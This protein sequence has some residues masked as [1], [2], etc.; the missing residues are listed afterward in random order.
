MCRGLS[1]TTFIKMNSKEYKKLHKDI[2]ETLEKTFKLADEMKNQARLDFTKTMEDLSEIYCND[3]H[4]FNVGDRV[5]LKDK[6]W[7]HIIVSSYRHDFNYQDCGYI[8]TIKYW[9]KF[10]KD[11]NPDR[12]A[13][14]KC[15]DEL[16]LVE[17]KKE[18]D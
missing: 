15:E 13:M 18:G 6:P 8:P 14:I 1:K 11:K 9:L 12:I 5:R 16:E 2:T 4:K 17:N 7:L 10:I 3:N